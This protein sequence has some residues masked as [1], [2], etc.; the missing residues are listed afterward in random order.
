MY[1]DVKA[2]PPTDGNIKEVKMKIWLAKAFVTAF[3]VSAILY[4]FLTYQK[5]SRDKIYYTHSGD[6]IAK[7]NKE[8]GEVYYFNGVQGKW[9]LLNK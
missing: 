6:N 9:I 7:V 3:L 2:N 8:T 5:Y 4:G 1:L